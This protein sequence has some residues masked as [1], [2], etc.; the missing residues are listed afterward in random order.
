MLNSDFI[1]E[2]EKKK[3]EER[4]ELFDSVENFASYLKS[5]YEMHGFYNP[6]DPFLEEKIKDFCISNLKIFN[7]IKITTSEHLIEIMVDKNKSINIFTP[8]EKTIIIK[9]EGLCLKNPEKLKYHQIYF[10]LLGHLQKNNF[11][12]DKKMFEKIR[13]LILTFRSGS[14]SPVFF[15]KKRCPDEVVTQE[16]N[17]AMK[18]REDLKKH[19]E[20]Q[21]AYESELNDFDE[22]CKNTKEKMKALGFE[23]WVFKKCIQ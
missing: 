4:K 14:G 18:L 8:I 10:V 6:M 17:K 23:N 5:H 21:K 7:E 13:N 11:N 15:R 19:N 9:N 2:N 22:F 3:L 16:I 12:V 20:K 1:F